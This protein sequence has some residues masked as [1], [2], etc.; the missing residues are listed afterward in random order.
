MKNKILFTDKEMEIIKSLR[1]MSE[2][3]KKMIRALIQKLK[4]DS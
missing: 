3:N 4:K 1:G 2:E